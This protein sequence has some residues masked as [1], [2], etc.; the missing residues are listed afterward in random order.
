M[1]FWISILIAIV[2]GATVLFLVIRH[3]REI[4]LLDVGTI[5]AEQE[6]KARDR[7]VR[8]RFDR[9]L[10]RWSAPLR[11]T[12]RR[13]SQW[14][15]HTVQDAEKKLGIVRPQPNPSAAADMPSGR[16]MVLLEEA[17]GLAREGKTSHAERIYLEVLKINMRQADAYRG[18]GELYLADRQY[19]Q[20]KETFDFLV[21]MNRADDAVYA[22]LATIA[23]ADNQLLDAERDRK[24]AIEMK[25]NSSLR[26]AELATHYLKRAMAKEALAATEE[27][28]RLD[29]SDFRTLELSCRAAILLRDRQTA[30]RTLRDLRLNGYDRSRLDSLREQ[31][32]ELGG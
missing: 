27:A 3:W 22:G 10:R 11:Q 26:F 23:E 28:M 31:I 17:A 15:S 24:R 32:D 20:A 1:L 19:A 4:R 25:P 21:S 7:I 12:G 14:F 9:L 6:R 16:V 30:E 18:L 29:P 2:S 13:A 8:D 5:R